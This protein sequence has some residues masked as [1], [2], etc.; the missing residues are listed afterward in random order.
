MMGES[1]MTLSGE[2]M[3]QAQGTAAR[4]L[5]WEHAQHIPKLTKM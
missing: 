1:L 2:K 3:F 5:R 4:V